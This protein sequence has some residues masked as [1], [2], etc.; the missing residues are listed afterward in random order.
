MKLYCKILSLL[1][2]ILCAACNSQNIRDIVDVARSEDPVK[3]AGNVLEQKGRAIA[4]NPESLP[5][6]LKK[7]KAKFEKFRRVVD[8]IW[9][10]K[11]P[12]QPG[13][14]DYVKYTDKYYNRAHIDFEAGLVTV[15]TV[16]PDN[17][18]SYLKKAIV[19]TLLTPD[20][21]RKV[22]LYSDTEPVSEG[23][24]KPFLYQQVLD[25]DGQAIAW[26][27][28]AKRYADYLVT[29]KLNKI[30]L[31]KRAG[32]RVQFPLI[33][34]HQQLRAYKYASL[35]QK[36]SRKYSVT[37]SLIYG[38]IKTESSFNPFAVSHAPAYGL[39]QIVPR[40]AGKD[41]FEK[42]KQK[43]GQP[44]PQYLYD[45]ENNIDT[46]TAYL[47][48]LQER[49]L[50]KVRNSNARRYSVISAYN[51]GAGN[52]LKTFSSD[53]N[54]AI[55]KINQL[56]PDQVYDQLTSK[57]PSQESRR[58]LY[59]VTEAQKEFWKNEGFNKE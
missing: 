26:E 17:Q 27:W 48:I 21:P 8:E 36:Y 57:H 39:M 4:S 34:S 35:V 40:T 33:A 20:D 58:Y 6:E 54:R 1:I 30:T 56:S 16:A 37:E 38:V 10:D 9:G 12:Q 50:V 42:I 59:K 44:S 22:D 51:G 31:A 55:D 41:V 15:E 49:Y 28:R 13:P 25:H 18:K 29:N 11:D 32:L 19:T 2:L 53:R 3:Q 23:S 47:K 45:P 43:P 5:Q 14:K 24:G 46:G 7:L 52:V